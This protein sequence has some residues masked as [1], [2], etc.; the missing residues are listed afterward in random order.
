MKMPWGMHHGKDVE[1]LDSG[2]LQWLAENISGND[3]LV[4]E[5]ENQL[6]LREGQGV[7]RPGTGE[8]DDE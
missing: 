1:D 6:R 7:A 2:Y 5:V 3:A 8:G 4:R